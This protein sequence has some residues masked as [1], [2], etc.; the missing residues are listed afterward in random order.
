MK[1]PIHVF[2]SLR[3]MYIRYL[4]SPFDLRYPELVRERDQLLSHDGRIYREPL[5][6]PVPLY[7]DCGQTF[8]D[9]AQSL[10]SGI[11]SPQEISD[12]ADFVSL[13]LFPSNRTPY[14]HQ[15]QVFE[16]AVLNGNDVI[17][18]TGTGSGKTECFL[19]P[20]LAALVKESSSWSAVR[21]QQPQWDWWNHGNRRIS[22]RGYEDP[23]LR[24]AA[25]RALV[26]YPL[27]ALVEDQLARLRSALDGDGARTWLRTR[28]AGNR[29][30]F[31]RYTGRTPVAGPQD[32]A[33]TRR[34]RSSLIELEQAFSQVTG[35]Q[36]EPYFP[37]ADGGE[38]WSRWDMQE[39]PPDILITNYSMLN[40]ML[41]RSLEDPIFDSTQQWLRADRSHVFHLIV[42]ELHTYRG[43]PGT[44]VAYLIR[45]LLERL[46]LQPDSPQLR[47]IA[48]SASVTGDTA[49]LGYLESFFGRDRNQFAIVEGNM[50]PLK[51][52]AVARVGTHS[53]A[54]RDLGRNL[55]LTTDD[56][57]DNAAAAFSLAV[58]ASN[59]PGA[60]SKR[61]LGIALDHIDAS[62]AA[63]EVCTVGGANAIRPR[64]PAEI[65][66]ALFPNLP[67][68]ERADAVE[69][70]L[71]GLC[72]ARSPQNG[73]LLP[74]RAHMFFR[75][76]QGLWV[77][78]NPAC[79]AVPVQFPQRP[80]GRLHYAP[81]LTCSCGSRI[82]ELLYCE[83]CGEVFVGGYRRPGSGTYEWYLSPDHPDLEKSPD[84]VSLDRDYIRY[85]VFWPAP[86]GSRPARDRWS[87]K[88]INRAWREAHLVAS[89]AK[90]AHGGNPRAIRGY[91]Y[92]V[93]AFHQPGGGFID[94]ATLNL[95]VQDTKSTMRAYPAYCP[96]CETSWAWSDIGSPIRTQRTGF[97]KLAQ[98]LSEVIVREAGRT[99]ADARKLVVFLRMTRASDDSGHRDSHT[100]VF[101]SPFR[102]SNIVVG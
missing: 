100:G 7:E 21:P 68:D 43:T 92:D 63:R 80:V 97:Q 31:G 35:S 4:D 78:V 81:T 18:T 96:R 27:N 39:S 72:T 38:M 56:S 36:A 76:L 88:N 17:V 25:V 53:S 3:E 41:M 20:I 46:G 51:P 98:V 6:E 2:N 85:A 90:V 9:M 23:V 32:A 14:I 67:D 87:E 73:A 60:D 5:I 40:I 83:A 89:E 66:T 95:S 93:P 49:G 79:N 37:R 94:P 64:T 65:G 50:L 24:P 44:E 11:W 26:L 47:I 77:C 62:S 101:S 102:R 10:L 42:D 84:L 34:L 22:Q 61:L 86:D 1:N 99:D 69:G 54:L 71:A 19:L 13:K 16:E 75:N 70:L 28:R 74:I 8:G 57:V 30:Y 33:K 48:S 45:V 91:L 52:G 82:L 59:Q 12:L 29:F 15:R 55:R 58:G